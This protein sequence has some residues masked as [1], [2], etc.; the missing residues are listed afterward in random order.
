M[1]R[2]SVVVDG[3][4][5]EYTD[6][7]HLHCSVRVSLFVNLW[8]HIA[9]FSLQQVCHLTPRRMAILSE[10]AVNFASQ[11]CMLHRVLLVLVPLTSSIYTSRSCVLFILIR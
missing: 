9:V 7:I 11:V 4:E 3:Q 5:S 10:P 6:S 2:C 8:Y 1:N